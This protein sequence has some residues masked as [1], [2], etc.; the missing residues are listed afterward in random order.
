VIHRK[1]KRKEKEGR[2][3]INGLFGKKIKKKNQ[4]DSNRLF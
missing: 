2:K 1:E 3:K 4:A